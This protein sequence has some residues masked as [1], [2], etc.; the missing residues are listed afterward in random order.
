MG[1][2]LFSF[3]RSNMKITVKQVILIDYQAIVIDYGNGNS[4]AFDS[5]KKALEKFEE[6]RKRECS[7][8]QATKNQLSAQLSELRRTMEILRQLRCLE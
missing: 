2:G 3:E 6:I 4:S 8:V 5:K 1:L 7:R